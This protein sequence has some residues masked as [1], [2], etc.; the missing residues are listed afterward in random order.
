MSDKEKKRNKI[1][2]DVQLE[3]VFGWKESSRCF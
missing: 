1:E 2:I 3:Q